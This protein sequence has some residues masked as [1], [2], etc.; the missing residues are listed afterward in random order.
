MFALSPLTGLAIFVEA[1]VVVILARR[2]RLLKLSVRS[3]A[4]ETFD[5]HA[6]NVD[7]QMQD[8]LAE[9][10]SLMAEM[11]QIL[12]DLDQK[13]RERTVELAG[14]M[15]KAE[16]GNK[17]KSEFLA[18]ISH[19]IRTPMNGV[20]GMTGLL[21]DTELSPE[22]REWAETVRGSAN[23][24]LSIINEI[25][26]FSKIEAGK[27]ELE[28]MDCNVRA[29]VDDVVE[30][31]ME[32]AAAK[33]IELACYVDERVPALVRSDE[34]RLRQVLINLVGNAIKF[35]HEGRVFVHVRVQD[36]WDDRVTLH[37]AV[38][39]SGIGISDEGLTRLFQPF[40]QAD[41]ST[42]RKYGGTGLGLA[43]SRQ[44]AELMGGTMDVRSTAGVGSV[45]WFTI[46]AETTVR[47]RAMPLRLPFARALV[48]VD[49]KINRVVMRRHLRHWGAVSSCARSLA[50]VE[51][52]L[53]A[54]QAAGVRYGITLVDVDATADELLVAA[55]GWRLRFGETAGRVIA[56]VPA[57]ARVDAT[58]AREA[59]VDATFVKPLRP[60]KLFDL[61]HGVFHGDSS[62]S[63]RSR[64]VTRHASRP[65]SYRPD[66]GTRTDSRARVLVVE[67]N[68]VN[69]KV[70]VHMLDKLGYRSDVASNGLEAVE[71]LEQMPYDLVLMDCHMPEMDGYTA[72]QLIREREAGTWQHLPII[73]MT[74]N[75]MRE[76]R[77][78]CLACGMDGFVP[79]PIMID[80]LDSVLACWIHDDIPVAQPSAKDVMDAIEREAGA[81]ESTTSGEAPALGPIDYTVLETLRTLQDNGDDF[82]AGLIGTF[83]TD[84]VHRLVVA[85]AAAASRDVTGVERAVHAVKGSSANLGAVGLAARCAAVVAAARADDLEA[86]ATLLQDVD[87]EFIVVREIFT[88]IV[89]DGLTQVMRTGGPVN[90]RG[91]SPVS[92]HVK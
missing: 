15:V 87:A 90:M 33:R 5:A 11:Q 72:T 44:L 64:H 22:Q 20:I 19:E 17:A 52:D 80:E 45:F 7:A 63:G 18:R 49:S 46:D 84:T 78:L 28:I 2:L 34:G 91:V 29:A 40:Q 9:R 4:S 42:T 31:L 51:P 25:L 92:M 12:T 3:A 8:A 27:L 86:A 23:A 68:P 47:L 57:R 61:L 67:D 14:A 79:K 73:A 55:R 21:L 38:S 24:L 53:A 88:K 6:T 1:A 81:S 83:L 62:R 56:L 48:A 54:A 77:A 66:D 71:M 37:F 41:S 70:A 59:G 75:A 82:V 58:L 26:D 10:E 74:A 13:V 89:H 39:D 50:E 32:Q 36:E 35:T 65:V 85:T 60:A 76:D 16:Q 43:I 69:Q 30:L